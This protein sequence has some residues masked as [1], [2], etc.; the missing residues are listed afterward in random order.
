MILS[1]VNDIELFT[2]LHSKITI[3]NYNFNII[4][5]GNLIVHVSLNL[6]KHHIK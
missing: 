2:I 1:V 4:T 5:Q 6:Y 3:L